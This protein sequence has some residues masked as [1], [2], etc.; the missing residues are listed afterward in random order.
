ML[1][2]TVKRKKKEENIVELEE[3]EDYCAIEAVKIKRNC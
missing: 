3:G 1:Y 2:G